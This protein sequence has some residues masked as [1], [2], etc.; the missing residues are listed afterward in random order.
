MGLEVGMPFDLR[1]QIRG[2]V[3]K[4]PVFPT[5]GDSYTG[6]SPARDSSLSGGETIR[7]RAIPLGQPSPSSRS[8]ETNA[9][10]GLLRGSSGR[11]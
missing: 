7:A 11:S 8:Q 3:N 10:S 1:A 4:K 6:L 9:N 2:S 5:G